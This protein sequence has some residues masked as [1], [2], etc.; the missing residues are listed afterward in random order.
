M[1][2][3]LGEDAKVVTI[4]NDQD[5]GKLVRTLDTV[6]VN[7]QPW[8]AQRGYMLVENLKRENNMIVL[9]GFLKGNCINANQ[10]VHLTGF[11]DYEI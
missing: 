10:L 2:S 9:E 4:L 5:R 1:T 8:K 7:P 6:H 11:D 3:Q